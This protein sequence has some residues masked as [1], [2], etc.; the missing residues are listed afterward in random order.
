MA[1]VMVFSSPI[2]LFVFL[3]VV[4]LG[5]LF[6]NLRLRNLWLLGFSLIFYAWGEV[7]FVFLML[8]SALLNYFLGGWVGRETDVDRRK[9]AIA[10]AIGLNVG[11]LAFFKYANFAVDNLNRMLALVGAAP[12]GVESIRLPLGISFFTFHALSYVIDIYRRK[13]APAKNPADVALYIFFFPQLI[14]GPILRWN[15]IAPQI[16]GRAQTA[17]RFAQGVRRFV[18]GLA[19]KVLI[20]NVV[21]V[22][23]DQ[24]FKMSA[25]GQEL[26]PEVAW[27]GAVCYMLQ[28]YF[29]FSGYSD[30]AIGLGKMFGFEFMEN[31]NYPYISQSIREF[32]RRWHISLS[33]W[34][35]DYLYI[36]LGGNR[37]SSTRNHLN[38][39]IVFFLCGLWHGASWTFVVW[40]L[41]HGF[42][43]VLEHA[44]SGRFSGR[45]ARPLRHFYAL[46]VVLAG[47]VL[48]RA[49]TFIDAIAFLAN[50]I[51]IT[52]A[53]AGARPLQSLLTHQVAC[54]VIAG[55]A[56]STPLWS[57]L[58]QWTAR[59][60]ETLPPALGNAA[61]VTGAIAHVLLIIALLIISSAWLAGGTYNPFIYFRF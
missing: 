24:I 20:A 21:A 46:L 29:D 22:P 15:A 32:W 19:R 2:F 23:S 7:G 27:L 33:S 6:R 53:P 47:W 31:F 5:G 35:R 3:P 17:E 26:R 43:I 30:M 34:F 41:Y 55:M 58:K 14:A 49:P 13:W 25:N 28:I 60:L 59:R 37:C 57:W 39:L 10:L 16:A 44:G 38:L 11:L 9:W 4:L 61:R 12:V 45:A 40:G 36:P 18:E 52:S 42:F 8:G 54:A 1:V 48:F 51:G 50:M 56:F